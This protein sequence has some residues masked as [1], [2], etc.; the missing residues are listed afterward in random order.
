MPK[1]TLSFKG[2]VINVFHLESDVTHIGRDPDCAIQIDSLAIAPHQVTLT[3][4]DN[5]HFLEACDEAYP[6]FV[7]HQQQTKTDLH[8]GDVIQIGKH[9]LSYAEDAIDLSNITDTP[10]SQPQTDAE[11]TP[12]DALDSTASNSILQVVNGEHFGRVIPLKRNMTRLGHTGGD[13]AMIARREEGYFISFLEGNA[14]PVINNK[15]L[16]KQAQ[17]LKDG[18]FIEIGGTMMQFHT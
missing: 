6:V 18:D 2:H 5:N 12:Q 14:P 1:L 7:N 4:Q 13:C 15:P 11:P 10:L 17:L 9:T 3:K 8:H 16:G